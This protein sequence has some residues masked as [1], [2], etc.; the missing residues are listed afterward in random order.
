MSAQ[1]LRATPADWRDLIRRLDWRQEALALAL[2]LAETAL[3]YLVCGYVLAV[4]ESGFA[5]L[6][7]WIVGMLMVT[8]HYV[9]HLM[10]EWR[11]WSPSYE[12]IT[13]TAIGLSLLVAIKAGCFPH[14][15][16]Y[17]PDWLRDAFNSL[18]FL[19]NDALR[20]AWGPVVLAAYAWWRGRTRAEPALDSTYTMLRWGSLALALILIIVLSAAPDHAQVRDRLSIATLTFFVC[21]LGAIGIA[22]LRLEGFRTSAP[23]GPRWLATFVTPILVVVVV[24]VIAAGIF[25]RQFLDTTLWLLTPL[26]WF[27]AVVFQIFVL[28]LAI[29]AFIVLTPILWLI[30]SREPRAIQQTPTPQQNDGLENLQRRAEEAINV[31]DPLRYLIASIVLFV[32]FSALMRFVFRRRR[33][34]RESTDEQRE[35]VLDWGNLLDDLAARL[36]GI[37][38]RPEREDP[39]RHLRGDPRWRYTLAIRETYARLQERGAK[40]GRPRRVAETADEYRPGVAAKLAQ[41]PDVPTAIGTITDRYRQARY[42]GV[43]A[44]APDADAVEAAWQ[45]VAQAPLGESS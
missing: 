13:G 34:A 29:I 41:P 33:R 24:A 18:A 3:V 38:E 42:S 10:D 22:R 4:N 35:S 28:T 2:V 26:F 31:P 19:P 8:A 30:G 45:Q 32:I 6:P 16:V 7:A 39:L 11:V 25:S 44:E 14:M 27:L 23:L 9:P 20:S 43:P 40:A 15:A 21:A 5:V 17:D 36:K 1:P 12:V 37:F